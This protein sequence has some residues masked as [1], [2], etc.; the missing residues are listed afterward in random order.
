M[1]D[2][3]AA[4]GS[5]CRDCGSAGQNGRFCTDCGAELAPAP[6]TSTVWWRR[7]PAWIAA[8]AVLALVVGVA[9]FAGVQAQAAA[10]EQQV[11]A[12]RHAAA[13]K[14]QAD[15]AAKAQA[16]KDAAA[17]AAA[18][19]AAAVAAAK[20]QD[21]TDKAGWD[22]KAQAAAAAFWTA[23]QTQGG[24]GEVSGFPAYDAPTWSTINDLYSC[25][26]A[27]CVITFTTTSV[28]SPGT[29]WGGPGGLPCVVIAGT[30]VCSQTNIQDPQLDGGQTITRSADMTGLVAA[31]A[32]ISQFFLG[33]PTTHA[34]AS[35]PVQTRI[36]VLGT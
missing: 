30:T 28:Q 27:H 3:I 13:V 11:V 9:V 12:V 31:G 33:D 1:T 35:P 25:T 34:P 26:A 17:K 22:Q 15:A 4:S 14:A 7:R 24:D 19:K 18:A 20:G 32:T 10:H 21:A 2:T 6:V 16:V 5:F 23:I 36:V 29:Q 8:G